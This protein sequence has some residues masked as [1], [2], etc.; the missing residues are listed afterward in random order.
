MN[1]TYDDYDDHEGDLGFI[2]FNP[3]KRLKRTIK[4]VKRVHNPIIKSVKTAGRNPF[5]EARNP[6]ASLKR[7]FKSAAASG[8]AAKLVIKPQ[9]MPKAQD[10]VTK[11]VTTIKAGHDSPAKVLKNPVKH[12]KKRVSTINKETKK[13]AVGAKQ[14]VAKL[15]ATAAT[16]KEKKDSKLL[17]TGIQNLIRQQYAKTID[18]AK[19]DAGKIQIKAKEVTLA[20]KSLDKVSGKDFMR[21]RQARMMSA[22]TFA[23]HA[24][25]TINKK[26]KK[27]VKQIQDVGKE[28]KKL[29]KT[30]KRKRQ[31]KR[32]IKPKIETALVSR[33]PIARP[34]PARIDAIVDKKAEQIVKQQESD[35]PN[36][37]IPLGISAALSFLL[38]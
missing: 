25:A 22:N 24:S 7:N 36:L 29:V 11:A 27:E 19:K 31:V 16:P 21:A 2:K 20:D 5:K 23:A 37:L 35:K 6:V 3:I 12:L 14:D 17:A 13:M 32:L 8:R 30:E 28:I 33:G 10:V 34:S 1:S 26:R 38:L 9:V 4:Q 18:D 15:K